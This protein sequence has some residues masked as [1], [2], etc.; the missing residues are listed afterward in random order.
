M[1]LSEK[2]AIIILVMVSCFACTDSRMQRSDE[3]AMMLY[4]DCMGGMSPQ[5]DP[6]DTSANLGSEHVASASAGADSRPDSR[7]QHEGMQRA[8]G[9]DK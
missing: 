8:S 4:R 3:E 2:A 7:L 6:M 1:D 9:E 5:W